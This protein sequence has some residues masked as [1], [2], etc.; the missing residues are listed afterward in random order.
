MIRRRIVLL[1]LVACL[2]LMASVSLAADQVGTVSAGTLLVR[3][4]P[5]A[6]ATTVTSV[7]RGE[8]VT[9]LRI[10]GEWYYVKCSNNAKGYVLGLFITLGDVGVQPKPQSAIDSTP[11][12]SNQKGSSPNSSGSQTTSSSKETTVA[13]GSLPA[14]TRMGDRG[15]GVKIIQQALANYGYYTGNVD[16]IFGTMTKKA[17][18]SFQKD[19]ALAVDGIV[20]AATMNVLFGANPPTNTKA[21]TG[22]STSKVIDDILP[23]VWFDPV[24]ETPNTSN[25]PVTASS[26]TQS[27]DWFS[28]GYSLIS[29]NRNITI[30]DL[31]SGVVWNA[32]YINGSSHADII[33]ASLSDTQKITSSKI[34]GSYV[35]RPVIVTIAGVD[36]AGSM[37][38]VSHG[39]T[40]Y[41]DYFK[42][43]MCIHFTGSQ[44]HGT[45]KVDADHQN[46]I[47]TALNYTR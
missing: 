37:Y 43:V 8:Q 20:G 11:S 42:G 27:L 41:C 26:K 35:R 32:R 7:M 18:M 29:A 28:E 15:E 40:S 33:P 17:V 12:Y 25:V 1:L 31:N 30:Y 19:G 23:T 39:E 22:T 16:G 13:S 36:Y 9:I 44:T 5:F 45:K 10:E 34:V 3:E 46:A 24:N 4:A 2:S 14:T 21:P 38:A 6:E 47:K